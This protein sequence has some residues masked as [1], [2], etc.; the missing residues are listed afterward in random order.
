MIFRISFTVLLVLILIST[1][2]AQ[3]T[4]LISNWTGDG[5]ADDVVGG[6]HG[7]LV[8]G[9][10]FTTGVRGQ[11]FAFNGIDNYMQAPTVGLPTGNADRTLTLWVKIDATV[12]N[13]SYFGGYGTPG[14]AT[15]AY[16]LGATGAS[17]RLFF[18]Q[19]GTGVL[20]PFLQ[21]GRWYHVAVTNIGNQVI[22]Y[23]DGVAVNNATV[24]IA[25]SGNSQFFIGRISGTLGD[26][27][28]LQGGVDDVRVY[29]RALSNLEIQALFNERANPK[30]LFDF[31]GDNKSDIS[32]FRPSVG[33]WWINRSSSTVI[34][35]QFGNS[36]DKIVPADFSGDGQTD[37]AFWRPS[38][39]EW[40]ILRSEDASYYS[41]PF[42]TAGD[43]PA[44]ADYDGDGKADQAVFRPT[45][46]V[47][48][49]SLSSGETTIQQFGTTGDV[50]VAA[51]YDG[52]GK[53]DI[54]IY[55]SSAGEW[56]IQRSTAGLVAFQ[57]G[58][59]SDK[60]VQSDYT[61]DGKADAG[62]FRPATGE[63]FILRSED[64]S[65]FSIPFGTT[66]DIPSPGDYDGDGKSDLAVFR[67]SS[68]D[69]FIQRSTAGTL[70]QQFGSTGDT[71]VPSAFV[72]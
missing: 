67:P 65:Y 27:R 47:W 72:P 11:A 58:N 3:T 39:G 52:D 37:I 29:G 59:S 53:T 64:S 15:Q 56:W 50:P 60:P 28:R 45:T 19:W 30:T 21:N 10:A 55:R 26:T 62:L 2:S 32:I 51:D 33:E 17:N 24:N 7:T 69:W 41:V 57:F 12:A 43:I 18:T 9:T 44:P 46:G 5:N 8:N 54:A 14:Q 16:F 49:I 48:Y 36:S 1:T 35:A 23:L 6:N 71:P 61:G 22:L 31:D 63:W 34:A 42:G 68:S 70:I 66:G 20:G 40:F 13:E 38:T 25:T 4:G